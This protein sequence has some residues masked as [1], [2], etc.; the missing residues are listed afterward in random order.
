MFIYNRMLKFF[1]LHQIAIIFLFFFFNSTV[2]AITLD[3]GVS[4]GSIGFEVKNKNGHLLGEMKEDLG[5]NIYLATRFKQN[6]GLWDTNWGY[7]M[8]FGFGSFNIHTQSV[9][10]EIVNFNTDVNGKYL[11]LTWILYYKHRLKSDAY[12]S[13]G[14]GLGVGYLDAEGDVKLTEEIGEPIVDVNVSDISG[15]TGF[16]IEY[17]REKWFM[18]LVSIGPRFTEEPYEFGIAA[19][20]LIVGH[21]FTW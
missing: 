6:D 2:N 16:Y 12:F 8:E 9:D 7:L 15:S 21:R 18:R 17:Q 19:T 4:I 11:Y 5:E 13:Y 14:L 10:Q 3:V 20:R 1:S